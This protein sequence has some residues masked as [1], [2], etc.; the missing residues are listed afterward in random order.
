MDYLVSEFKKETILYLI[1]KGFNPKALTILIPK[2]KD[3]N[4]NFLFGMIENFYLSL[5]SK[6]LL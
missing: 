4:S 5:K 2:I 6:P 1:N 3:E